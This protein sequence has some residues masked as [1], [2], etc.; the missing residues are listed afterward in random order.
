MNWP[1]GVA[2]CVDENNAIHIFVT[3]TN[4]DR[5]LVWNDLPT[6]NG[7]A[8]DFAMYHVVDPDAISEWAEDNSQVQIQLHVQLSLMENTLLLAIIM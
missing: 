2:A 8:A 6:E 3:D 7:E 4:N 1:V 5:I